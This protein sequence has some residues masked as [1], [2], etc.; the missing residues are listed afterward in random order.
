MFRRGVIS[1]G[2]AKLV[3]A[4]LLKY[5]YCTIGYDVMCF[6]VRGNSLSSQR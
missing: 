2:T 1:R 6:V 3:C 4:F 5:W